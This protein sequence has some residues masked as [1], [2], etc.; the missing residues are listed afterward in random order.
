MLHTLNSKTVLIGS[1]IFMSVMF[2]IVT[3][4]VNPAIDGGNGIGVLKLQL[5]FDKEV[6]IAIIN[7]WGKSGIEHFKEWIFTDYIYAVSYA[8]FF[9]SL[10]SI[11][12]M[13]KGKEEFFV[14][15]F[16][17]YL[18][19]IAGLLDWV[20]NSIELF[21]INDPSG[22]SNNVFFLHSIVAIVKWAALPVAIAYIAVLLAT[23]NKPA[24]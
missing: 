3:F 24:A 1:V 4:L 6:G 8:V 23:A 7:S 13:K 21:F 15:R 11:L 12:I 5:S 20:E 17:V 18:A 22:F 14:Y 19:V 2:V 9:A 16:G 10:L